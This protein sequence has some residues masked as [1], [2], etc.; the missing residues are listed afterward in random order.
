MWSSS[1]YFLKSFLSKIWKNYFIEYLQL[2][3]SSQATNLYVTSFFAHW[4]TVNKLLIYP[5]FSIS[6]ISKTFLLGRSLCFYVFRY[7]SRCCYCWLWCFCFLL[8]IYPG[9][10]T[11]IKI[12]QMS[13]LRTFSRAFWKCFSLSYQIWTGYKVFF[14]ICFIIYCRLYLHKI[15]VPCFLLDSPVWT[16]LQ[17]TKNEV[18]H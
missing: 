15:I 10:T 11:W 9:N 16:I 5:K 8:Y 2:Y 7:F 14:L 12:V 18:S 1:K 4:K 17:C 6:S 3:A 13:A